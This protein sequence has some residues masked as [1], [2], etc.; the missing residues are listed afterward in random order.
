MREKIVKERKNEN[1]NQ[2]NLTGRK[3]Q[4]IFITSFLSDRGDRAVNNDYLTY[5]E[6]D[7]YGC[8]VVV[9]GNSGGILERKTA[10]FI[11][12]MIIE[13]FI[14][15]PTTDRKQLENI[16]NN[17][18]RRYREMQ[19]NS[20][21][22]AEEYSSCSI[23]VMVTDYSKVT[24][25]NIGN[26]RFALLRDNNII[27]RSRDHSIAF[28]MYEAEKILYDEIRFRKDKNTLTHRFG[29]DRKIEINV[30][31][32]ITLLP[33]DKIL[34][35]TKGVWENLD[36]AD[37]EEEAARSPRV[38]QWIGGLVKRIH[39]NC[40]LNMGN[41]TLCGIVINRPAPPI[42]EPEPKYVAAA[43]WT[44]NNYKILGCAFLVL[45]L[46]FGC[47]RWYRGRKADKLYSIALTAELNAHQSMVDR[48][49]RAAAEG[50]LDTIDKYAA[51]EEYT[52]K[53]DAD[54]LNELEKNV[55]QGRISEETARLIKRAESFTGDQEFQKAVEE[56]KKGSVL[57]EG[58][59]EENSLKDEIKT[60]L[61]T[62]EELN[63]LYNEKLKADELYEQRGKTKRERTAQ[64]K[65]AVAI[66]EKIAP[67]FLEHKQQK[68][69][70][71]IIAKL[72][73]KKPEPKKAAVKVSTAETLMLE[74]DKAFEEFRYYKSYELYNEALKKT[75][76]SKLTAALKGKSE[77]NWIL[78]QGVALELEGDK[79]AK[80]KKSAKEAITKYKEAM[81][82]YKRLENNASMPKG[83]YKVI[84]E[85]L[86]K[87]IGG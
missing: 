58:L 48:K 39:K 16:L 51:V 87:K 68:I 26:A 76:D 50:Y 70:D 56:L 19:I 11:G 53:K 75:K 61:T 66:Y 13:L 52:G 49:Y 21:E 47:G 79:L 60:K 71:E 10:S 20:D 23:A 12:E 35:M 17:I 64:K 67:Q 46:F 18:H 6:L 38:G 63:T 59:N 7:N 33:G 57:A 32:P 29:I 40:Y 55:Q 83:R 81:A 69:Y 31:A 77:M 9:D 84:T 36:E 65:E 28:L 73:E 24:F 25:A 54:K 86:Q 44:K 80:N 14:K 62:A 27:K 22:G 1:R 85:R 34:L 37:I 2:L 8:W 4:S 78:L 15:S 41:H 43:G 30:T 5:I 82:Q 3:Y 72:E 45:F 74:G 42:T